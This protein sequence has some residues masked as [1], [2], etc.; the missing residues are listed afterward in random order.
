MAVWALRLGYVALAVG[1]AGLIVS[2]PLLLAIGVFVWLAAATFTL[3]GVFRARSEL[4][5]PR[6][7]Y[8]PM[9]W[10]LLHDTVRTRSSA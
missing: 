2:S 1:I 5:E 8:W 9:R 3:T 10:M 4:P 7:G 6:P